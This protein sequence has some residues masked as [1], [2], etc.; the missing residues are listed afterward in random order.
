[1][2]PPNLNTDTLD[3]LYEWAPT[4]LPP[5]ERWLDADPNEINDRY[6]VIGEEVVGTQVARGFGGCWPGLKDALDS[7]DWNAGAPTY[8]IDLFHPPTAALLDVILTP[9]AGDRFRSL[10]DN[11]GELEL[12]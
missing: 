5:K 6:V 2:K 4:G 8:I 1:M 11:A 12:P 7:Y 3:L 9:S 10:V